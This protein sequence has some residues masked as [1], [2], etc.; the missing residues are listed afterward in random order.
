MTTQPQPPGLLKLLFA[1]GEFITGR[2]D[3]PPAI[4]AAT[5]VFLAFLIPLLITYATIANKILGALPE[6]IEPDM[7]KS[8]SFFFTLSVISNGVAGVVM[9]VVGS[10]MLTCLSIIFDG[11]A[12]YR[13]MLELT[14]FAFLPLAIVSFGVMLFVLPFDVILKVNLEPG[15]SEAALKREMAE[16]IKAALS[17]TGF[18]LVHA[19]NQLGTIWTAILMVLSLKHAGKLSTG[20]SIFSL[21]LMA[22]FFLLVQYLRVKINLFEM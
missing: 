21:C 5:G 4:G 22:C 15:L 10:G 2:A 12:E 6:T 13:K 20:K 19:F 14:G 8:F 9:W 16:G 7:V 18:K 1:P 3:A 11:D 17:T